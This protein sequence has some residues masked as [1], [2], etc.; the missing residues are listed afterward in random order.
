LAP[1]KDGRAT[2]DRILTLIDEAEAK[3]IGPGS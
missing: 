1:T 3:D 2:I